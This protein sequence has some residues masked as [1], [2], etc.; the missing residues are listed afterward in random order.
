[1]DYLKEV[2]VPSVVGMGVE[3]VILSIVITMLNSS[4]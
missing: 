1:M 3:A 4:L 2:I